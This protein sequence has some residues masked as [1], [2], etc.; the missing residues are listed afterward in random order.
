MKSKH[1][2]LFKSIF[3]S[4]FAT[5]LA[6]ETNAGIYD[7]DKINL[8]LDNE[9]SGIAVKNKPE[10]SPKLVI[11]FNNNDT[12]MTM[13]H[14]SHSSHSSQSSHSSHSSHYSSYNSS[15]G[16][17]YPTTPSP[18]YSTPVPSSPSTT[19]YR[20][21]SNQTEAH[22]T[23]S[24]NTYNS[25]NKE[26][27]QKLGDRILKKGMTGTDVEELIDL[28]VLNGYFTKDNPDLVK[29]NEFNLN[30]ELS[31]IKYQRSKG[32]TADGIVGAKTVYYL[33]K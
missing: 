19:T 15:G 25:T 8:N 27:Q 4:S 6:T 31:V 5:L 7:L 14:R 17:T 11:R 20:S 9:N 16:S 24:N 3:L 26:Y 10:L 12:Y 32:L 21:N 22:S 30:V 28:L 1:I 33:K 29:Y 18:T 2:K 13:A 23:T